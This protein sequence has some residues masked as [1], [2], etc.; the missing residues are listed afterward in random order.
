[1]NESRDRGIGFRALAQRV[2]VDRS[3]LPEGGGGRRK[4]A[5]LSGCGTAIHCLIAGGLAR[6]GVCAF[7]AGCRNISGVVSASSA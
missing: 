4:S 2:R 1:L 5:D 6:D 3:L 7:N